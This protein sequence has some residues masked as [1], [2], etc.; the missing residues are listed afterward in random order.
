[1]ISAFINRNLIDI[2]QNA[3]NA[4]ALRFFSWV[5]FVRKRSLPHCMLG[6]VCPLLESAL[7]NINETTSPFASRITTPAR[8]ALALLNNQWM[9]GKRKI[10]AA[11]PLV[12]RPDIFDNRLLEVMDFEKIGEHS[13]AL[14]GQNLTQQRAYITSEIRRLYNTILNLYPH[15]PLESAYKMLVTLSRQHNQYYV[16]HA[17]NSGTADTIDRAIRM[18]KI[19]NP[20]FIQHNSSLIGWSPQGHPQVRQQKGPHGGHA[21]ILNTLTLEGSN[22]TTVV[23]QKGQGYSLTLNFRHDIMRAKPLAYSFSVKVN[24]HQVSIKK[25]LTQKGRKKRQYIPTMRDF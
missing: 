7:F 13:I 15:S 5:F 14:S 25:S 9:A 16:Q 3:P 21:L 22:V 19:E 18:Q 12:H 11:Q 4:T 6:L 20:R 2:N 10:S 8:H 17:I 23:T 24:H 1:M